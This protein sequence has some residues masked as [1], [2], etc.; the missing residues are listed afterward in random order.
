MEDTLKTLIAHYEAESKRL[1]QFID[2]YTKELDY[3]FA[4]FHAQALFQV[5]GILQT[6]YSLQDRRH[7]EKSRKQN[8]IRFLEERLQAEGAGYMREGLAKMLEQKKQELDKLN[9]VSEP[10]TCPPNGGAFHE[11]LDNL[12]E[13]RIKGFALFLSQEDKFLFDF[14][15]RG[16]TLKVALPY[17]KRHLKTEMLSDE[18]ILVLRDM[19]F[20]YNS[21]NSRLSLSL[22]GDKTTIV[23]A[24][25]WRVA[26]IVFDLFYFPTFEG[27]SFL[28][29]RG[30][31]S[32]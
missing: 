28:G 22:R 1:H 12:L 5:N 8:G 3:Q 9:Q 16:Q 23:H 24:I 4:H 6:L 25:R 26:R 7:G 30:K 11:A 19:G 13:R 21:D 17:V 15:Y 2:E 31:T 18:N 20:T 29:I 27:K 32:R 14:S 10:V